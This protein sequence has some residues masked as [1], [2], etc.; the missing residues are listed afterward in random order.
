[1]LTALIRS[2]EPQNSTTVGET[3]DAS[4]EGALGDSHNISEGNTEARGK[5]EP[6]QL[7]Q[8]FFALLKMQKRSCTLV[9]R[10]SQS[11]LHCETLPD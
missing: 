11:F 5:Q 2:T 4:Q 8:G 3:A 1:M 10:S 7:T 6:S 9:A